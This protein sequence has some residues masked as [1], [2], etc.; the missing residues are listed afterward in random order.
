MGGGVVQ[1]EQAAREL[2]ELLP[3]TVSKGDEL[4]EPECVAKHELGVYEQLGRPCPRV[5]LDPENVEAAEA[6]NLSIRADL[7]HL[8]EPYLLAVAED[9][10][11]RASLILRVAGTLRNARVTEI[12]HPP[13]AKKPETPGQQMVPVRRRGRKRGRRG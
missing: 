12:L 6:M 2:S 10:E 9:P 8:A 7:R 5:D 1:T 4:N 3:R 11:E 13:P